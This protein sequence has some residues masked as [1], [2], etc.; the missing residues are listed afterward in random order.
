MGFSNEWVRVDGN[1]ATVGLTREAR[2]EI[3]EIVNISLPPVGKFFKKGEEIL[4]LESIKSAFDLYSPVSGR[5][6]SINERLKDNL[7]LINLTPESKGW[8][9]KMEVSDLKE[10][11]NL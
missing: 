7:G 5:V 1:V 11:E 6:I 2:E 9:F 4:V 10:L 3:G 8:I